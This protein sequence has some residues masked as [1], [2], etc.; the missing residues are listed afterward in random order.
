[1]ERRIANVELAESDLPPTNADWCD[2]ARFALSFDGY[3]HWGSFGKCA[4]IANR[5][6]VVYQQRQ[7][8]PNSL[9]ELRT[10][11]FFEQR[12]WRHF[13]VDPDEQAMGYIHALV[14]SIRGKVRAKEVD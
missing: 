3:E 2:I 11:L 4:D 13:G 1:M 9:T 7:I 14:E 8:L 6:L 10:C 5:G 12:R